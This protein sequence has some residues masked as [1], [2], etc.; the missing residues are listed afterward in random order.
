M[1]KRA[2]G[3]G[4]ISRRKD[5]SGK[6]VSWRGAVTV[7]MN[8]DGTLDRRWVS[9]KTQDEVREGMRRLHSE[10]HTGMLA[11]ADGLSVAAYLERW[12]EHK[13]RDT[14]PNTARSYRD[15]VRLYLAPHLGRVKLD[16]LRP[17]DLERMLTALLGAGKSPA[18]VAYALR[19]LKMALRQA[20]MW[21]LVPRNVGDAVRPPRV[22]RKEMEVWTPGE[23]ASFLE[24]AQAHRL[25]ALFHLAVMTGMRRGEVLGLKWSDIDWERKRLTVRHN[26]VEVR[27][28]YGQTAVK[29]FLDVGDP[30]TYA[31]RRPVALSPGTLAV[32]EA[33]RER[34][35]RER[36]ALGE[37]YQDDGLVFAS[38][39]GTPT[40]PRNLERAYYVLRERAQVSKIR[41]HDLRHTAASLMARKGVS[42]KAISEQLGHEDVAFT[43][44]VYTHLYDEQREVAALDMSDLFTRMTGVN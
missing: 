27:K 29:G 15:T 22:E 6:T 14:R 18:L 42:I 34:Q 32:L 20:V 28:E 31:S 21:G 36:A 3:E 12:I 37:A 9:G 11:D 41:F 4:T 5:K 16:K 8:P 44:R 33:Q 2:N 38:E 26:L 39:V 17:L 25:H 35:G 24:V 19:V 30:K 40:H 7:G 1:G 23:V 13:A 10:L 43:M